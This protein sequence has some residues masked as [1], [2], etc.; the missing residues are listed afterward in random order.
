LE[1][2]AISRQLFRRSSLDKS[3]SQFPAACIQYSGFRIKKGK[4]QFCLLSSA[5]FVIIIG[6]KPLFSSKKL[7]F[8][9]GKI[10]RHEVHEDSLLLTSHK[11][12]ATTLAT[13]FPDYAV[14]L[15]IIN[16]HLSIINPF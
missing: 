13:D 3:S 2:S 10:F 4:F 15:K 9:Y 6:L 1:L 16:Y 11:P 12:R 7:D 5:F 8:Y 14:S